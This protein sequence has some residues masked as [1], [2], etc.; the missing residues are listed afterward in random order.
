MG[1]SLASTEESRTAARLDRD[2]E[3]GQLKQPDSMTWQ[4]WHP[5]RQELVWKGCKRESVVRGVA[6]TY[7][8]DR[9]PVLTI[10]LCGKW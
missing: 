3:L 1:V 8:P 9:A 4:T 2:R 10:M 6:N 7:Y 5:H